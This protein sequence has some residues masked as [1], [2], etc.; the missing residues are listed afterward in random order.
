M[1]VTINA[2]TSNGLVLTP[3]TSGEIKLQANGADI[4]TVSSTG[5]AMA[6]GKTLPA[7]ALTGTLPAID[8]SNLTGISSYSDSD[9]LS[10]LN[11][12]GSAPVYACRAWVNFNGDGTVAIRASGNVSSITDHGAGDYSANFTTALPDTNYVLSGT[13]GSSSGGN[14]HVWLSGGSALYSNFN[15]TTSVCR[16]QVV[17]TTSNQVDS[18]HVNIVIHR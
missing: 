18:G 6:S 1:A 8:G 5:I 14:S 10:L 7:S 2:D 13:V 12:S 16:F 3:D 15:R 4:A 17:Y 9:A 11:V